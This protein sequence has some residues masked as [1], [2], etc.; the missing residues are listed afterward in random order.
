MITPC[1]P[2]VAKLDALRS[3]AGDTCKIALYTNAASLHSLTETYTR[4]GE[5]RGQGYQAGG[6][7]LEGIDIRLDGVTAVMTWN[8]DPLWKNASISADGALIYNASRGNRAM[9]VIAFDK[10]IVSTNGN[11]RVPMPPATAA[12]ALIYLG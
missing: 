12:E 3:F 8:K 4:E 1:L 2:A 11:F 6:L 10:T 5:V 9:A 7:V